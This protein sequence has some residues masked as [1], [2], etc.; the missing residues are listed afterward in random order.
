MVC[1]SVELLLDCLSIF[2]DLSFRYGEVAPLATENF[3]GLC[4][5]EYYASPKKKIPMTYKGSRFQRII[6]GF[7][8]QGVSI[9]CSNFRNQGHVG[10]GIYGKMFDNDPFVVSQNR[11]GIVAMANLGKNRNAAEFY[12]TLVAFGSSVSL[13]GECRISG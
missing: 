4:T 12:I 2:G 11:P 7:I 10:V 8:V 6:P 1:P 5:G 13:L 3:R 9:V